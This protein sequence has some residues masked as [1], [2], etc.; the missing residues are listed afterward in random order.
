MLPPTKQPQYVGKD[1]ECNEDNKLKVVTIDGHEDVPTEDE[2][3]FGGLG[4]WG[5]G[6]LMGSDLGVS[7]GWG[8]GCWVVVGRVVC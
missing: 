3:G 1:G 5:L 4:V 2:V 8:A 7:V 6:N